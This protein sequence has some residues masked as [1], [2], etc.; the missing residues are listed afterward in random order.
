MMRRYSD[1]MV[2]VAAFA[3]VLAG[4]GEA[5]TIGY[6]KFEEAS[7]AAIDSGTGG[8]N[9]TLLGGAAR[10][11]TVFGSTPPTEPNTRSMEFFGNNGDAVNMGLSPEVDDSDFTLE[12]WVYV[13]TDGADSFPLLAG[14]LIGGNFLDRGFE[15]MARPDGSEGGEAGT[16]KWKAR[17]TIR[18]GGPQDSVYSADLDFNKWYHLAGVRKGT[19]AEAI[20]LYVDGHLA[21]QAASTHTALTSGQQFS[22]GGADVGGGVFGRAVD[23]FIDEVRLSDEALDR[24]EFLNVLNPATL[25]YWKFEEASGDALDSGTSGSDG[26]LLG[27]AARSSTVFG[28]TPQTEPNTRSMEFFGNNGDAVNMGLSPE[29]D[30]SDFTLEGWVYIRPDGAH[31]FPLLAGKL[32]SGNFSD[33]G[34]ELMARPD[35]SVGGEAGTGKWKARFAIR[36][37]GSQDQVLSDDLNFNKWYHLA[38]VR[39]G[40]GT[41]A[42]RLYVD[43]VLAGQ[44]ASTHTAL[45]SGQWFSIGGANTGGGVFGRAVDGFIDEVRLSNEALT[46]DLLLNA[47]PQPATLCLIVSALFMIGIRRRRT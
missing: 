14:K 22:I 18:F 29:V 40:T 2:L 13:R 7:G 28:S 8:N 21:G 5:A 23:G 16:G 38:G 41:G 34:F 24:S 19:G 20:S 11:S 46:P 47:V 4:T 15:L 3:M 37:G 1:V 45:T 30:D 43:G 25:G 27:G 44:A 9:G 31:S 26:T 17:F 12:A 10:S 35:G 33:R 36:F 32:I 6:W 42:V 39:E